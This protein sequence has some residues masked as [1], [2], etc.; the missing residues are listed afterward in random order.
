[1]DVLMPQLGETVLEGTVAL[2]YKKAG[3][4]VAKGDVLLDGP[5]VVSEMQVLAGGFGSGKNDL[6]PSGNGFRG[7]VRLLLRRFGHLRPWTSE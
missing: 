4:T 2:W 5:E 3:D 1:M 6:L 7:L